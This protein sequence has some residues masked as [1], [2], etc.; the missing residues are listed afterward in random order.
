MELVICQPHYLY[1]KLAVNDVLGNHIDC[2]E[3]LSKLSLPFS[4]HELFLL[5]C[6]FNAYLLYD[7]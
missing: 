1:H 6:R 4:K 2:G 5:Y 3:T 7:S